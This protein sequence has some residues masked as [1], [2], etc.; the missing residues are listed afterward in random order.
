MN[1]G[2][3]AVA[4]GPWAGLRDGRHCPGDA[5]PEFLRRDETERRPDLPQSR[6]DREHSGQKRD[7]DDKGRE[8]PRRAEAQYEQVLRWDPGNKE[9]LRRLAEMK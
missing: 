8:L 5:V 7:A 6:P 4:F 9:V 3:D 2:Q 1:H